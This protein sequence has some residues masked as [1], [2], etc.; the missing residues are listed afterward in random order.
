MSTVLAQY[1]GVPPNKK[2]TFVAYGLDND[3]KTIFKIIFNVGDSKKPNIFQAEM[4]T[5]MRTTFIDLVET[6][7]DKVTFIIRA[8]IS[9][10][11]WLNKH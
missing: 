11:L 1:N 7:Q 9:S 2:A 6:L 10:T 5:K 8:S 3:R 4:R